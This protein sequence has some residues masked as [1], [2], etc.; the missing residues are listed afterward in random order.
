MFDE[1]K[2]KHLAH[3]KQLDIRLASS[4]SSISHWA[5][6]HEIFLDGTRLDGDMRHYEIISKPFENPISLWEQA[7]NAGYVLAKLG[8]NVE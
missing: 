4:K 1:Q 6:I 3:A 8:V 7:F 5:F 2:A